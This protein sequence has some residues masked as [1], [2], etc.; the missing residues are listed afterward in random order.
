MCSTLRIIV[1]LL[2]YIALFRSLSYV[3]NVHYQWVWC[4]RSNGV[5][6]SL[7]SLLKPCRNLKWMSAVPASCS[8]LV[9]LWRHDYCE[10]L[11]TCG[12]QLIVFWQMM[13][14][15]PNGTPVSHQIYVIDLYIRIFS[16]NH[17]LIYVFLPKQFEWMF[18]HCSGFFQASWTII[19]TLSLRLEMWLLYE[20]WYYIW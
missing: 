4:V 17:C 14:H 9:L 1:V 2:K 11:T 12:T 5:S 8:V 13:L 19:L 20:V 16:D 7:H 10:N 18:C 3:Q 15:W 6:P